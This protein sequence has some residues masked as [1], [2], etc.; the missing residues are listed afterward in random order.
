MGVGGYCVKGGIVLECNNRINDW[1]QQ[2][3]QPETRIFGSVHTI[4]RWGQH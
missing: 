3:S 4:T 1:F 2:D